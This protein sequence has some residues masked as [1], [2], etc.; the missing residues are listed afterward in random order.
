[1]SVRVCQCGHLEC[2]H[3]SNRSPVALK[4]GICLT[5]ACGC[6]DFRPGDHQTGVRP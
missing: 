5:A 4:F 1:M 6:K 2:D 3:K